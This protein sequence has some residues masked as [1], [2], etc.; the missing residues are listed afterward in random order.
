MDLRQIGEPFEKKYTQFS[1]SD[2]GN[3]SGTYHRWQKE[4]IENIPEFCYVATFD[5]VK[6]KGKVNAP[7]ARFTRRAGLAHRL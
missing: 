1:E 2:I 5:E 7:F 6:K 3:I 4:Q